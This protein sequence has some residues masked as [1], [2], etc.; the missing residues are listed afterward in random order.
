VEQGAGSIWIQAAVALCVVILLVA[1][2]LHVFVR[3]SFVEAQYRR[4]SF[5]PSD[6]FGADERSKLSRTLVEYLRHRASYGDMAAL[7][8]DAGDLAMLPSELSHMADVRRVMDGFFVAQAVALMALVG[9]AWALWRARAWRLLT[10]G[11]R[12]GVVTTVALMGLILASAAVD[13]DAF[14][15][16]FHRLFFQEGTW[17][18]YYDDTLIQL[19]PLPLWVTAVT[20]VAVTILV[21]AGI[22]YGLAVWAEQRL[23]APA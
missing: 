9:G 8:T 20:A 7:R 11:V 10:A 2:P 5:P 23:A 18:F 17:V 21:E 6:R 22:L 19:Y 12:R 1:T 13:F 14:F 16:L 15:T 4:A 3:P